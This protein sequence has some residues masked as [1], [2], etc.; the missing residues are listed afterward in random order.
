ML[1]RVAW[2]LLAWSMLSTLT[3]PAPQ[4]SLTRTCTALAVLAEQ[5]TQVWLL[6]STSQAMM[7]RLAA[8]VLHKP[9]SRCC[10]RP[11][12][13][14]QTG[15]WRCQRCALVVREEGAVGRGRPSLEEGMSVATTPSRMERG[16]DAA[17]LASEGLV[18]VQAP[19]LVLVQLVRW[20]LATAAHPRPRGQ[21]PTSDSATAERLVRPRVVDLVLQR[22]R[23]RR[24]HHLC[25]LQ[26]PVAINHNNINRAAGAAADLHSTSAVV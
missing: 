9:C 17:V 19:V 26:E 10:E 7:P 6:P 2:T 20:V 23:R 8:G 13:W 3:S 16:E 12:K 21:H 14:C 22:R 18:E 5:A 15:S 4:T 11:N 1:P 25:R 24:Q